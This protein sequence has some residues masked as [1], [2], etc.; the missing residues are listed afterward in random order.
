M[1]TKLKLYKGE[2]LNEDGDI[3][4]LCIHCGEDWPATTEFFATNIHN[5]RGI[6]SCCIDCYKQKY[7]KAGGTKDWYWEERLF[8]E[9]K[10]YAALWA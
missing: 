2:F 10:E 5:A 4:K 6:S 9:Q 1:L 8:P 7:G 3:E